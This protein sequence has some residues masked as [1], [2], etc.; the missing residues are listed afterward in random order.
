MGGGD[1]AWA[2]AVYGDMETAYLRRW[3]NRLLRD[4][5]RYIR[6]VAPLV[7]SV[8][9]VEA[10]GIHL[11]HGTLQ[12]RRYGWRDTVLRRFDYD[13]NE[14]LEYAPNGT[15]RWT[16]AAPAEMVRLVTDYIH[17][18]QEDSA[19]DKEEDPDKAEDV[20]APVYPIVMIRR[21]HSRPADAPPKNLVAVTSYF[22]FGRSQ[23]RLRNYQR[24]AAHM[25]EQR[26]PLWTIE[27]AL[28]GDPFEIPDNSQ[29]RR[30]R[31][32]D[33]LWHELRLINLVW[34]L[35]PPDVDAV[36]WI[37]ANLLFS[38]DIRQATLNALA[39]WPLVQMFQRVNRLDDAGRVLLPEIEDADLGIAYANFRDGV[40]AV[41]PGTRRT[42][43]AW[44]ARREL[45]SAIGGL[46]DRYPAGNGDV[47]ACIGFFG[48]LDSR[49]LD[50]YGG[51]VVDEVRT[52]AAHARAVVRGRVGYVPGTIHHLYRGDLRV[53]QDAK[54]HEVLKA[55]GFD[56]ALHQEL[57]DSVYQLAP[58][59]PQEIRHWMAAHLRTLRQE[60]EYP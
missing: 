40:N 57:V 2:A 35:L 58:A 12:A 5:L 49:S 14:H 18:R 1:V 28:P 24:F 29:V 51:P 3:S 15:L 20:R 45:R 52:W 33:P 37:D 27:A 6:D 34:P 8:G 50:R 25:A 23:N 13:P 21:K 46:F 41:T 43:C 55:S 19:E 59:C 16:A 38:P 44:A 22:N 7:P 31:V 47:L 26:F 32:R 9:W 60:D 11:F 42:G 36:A 30:V 53:R 17:G 4:A 10:D 56:P 54:R 48:D 39:Q